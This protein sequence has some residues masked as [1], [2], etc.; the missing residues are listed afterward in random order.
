MSVS[1]GTESAA[2]ARGILH[3]RLPTRV[4][5]KATTDKD[6]EDSLVTEYEKK[7]EMRS[8]M[9]MIPMKY[10]SQVIR[11]AGLLPVWPPASN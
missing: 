2:K 10:L 3:L 8:P 1:R 6:Y 9:T 5:E 7:I 11:Y 4:T